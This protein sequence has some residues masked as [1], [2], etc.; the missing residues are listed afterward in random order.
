MGRKV[1]QNCRADKI[2][3]LKQ[4]GDEA[5]DAANRN[6]AK[7]LYQIVRKLR[8]SRSNSNTPIKDKNDKIVLTKEEQD[9]RWIEYFKETLNQPNPTTIFDFSASTI[10]NEI[11]TNLDMIT[12]TETRKTIKLLKNN[13]AAGLDQ[14]SAKLVK[15]GGIK[16]VQAMTKLLNM[17]WQTTNVPDEWRKGNDRQYTKKGN[18]TECNN[19]RGITLLSIPGKIFCIVLLS[20]IKEAVNKTLQEEQAR[21]C[22]GRSCN[23]QILTIR[24]IIEQ[25][26]EFQQPISINFIDFKKAFD[27]IHR[28]SLWNIAGTYR[29]PDRFINIF[30]NIYF[31]FSCCVKTNTGTTEFFDIVTGVRQGCILSPF[32]FFLVTD[33]VMWETMSGSDFGVRLR[34]Q[35]VIHFSCC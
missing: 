24:N 9:T 20:R 10:T 23:E 34:P 27:S 13:K 31:N 32:L 30:R 8:G 1:K 5:Q 18:V 28:E 11:E 35:C 16:M 15:H 22:N 4:K 33:F 25:S 17:C 29:I 3:W 2:E 26:I 7:T 21:F 14:I 19:W 6:D 12:E